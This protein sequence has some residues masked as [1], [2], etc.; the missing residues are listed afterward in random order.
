MTTT[1]SCSPARR[2]PGKIC[3][4]RIPGSCARATPT[5]A[6]TSYFHAGPEGLPGNDDGGTLSAWYVFAALGL[7]PD[8]PGSGR[9]ALARPSF[10]RV[11]IELDPSFY[12]GEQ[13]EI[14]ASGAEQWTLDGEPLPG[15]AIDRARLTAG[16]RLETP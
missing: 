6:G 8:C 11:A 5:G 3:S 12:A 9:F 16:G 14:A 2:S 15:A 7:Y 1:P 4:T 10:E 13:L